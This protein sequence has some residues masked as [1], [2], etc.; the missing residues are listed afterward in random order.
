MDIMVEENKK[1]WQEK[2]PTFFE[3]TRRARETLQDW[4]KEH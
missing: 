4:L 2:I 1:C 3:V